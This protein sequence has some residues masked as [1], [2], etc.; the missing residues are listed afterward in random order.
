MAANA[1]LTLTCTQSSQDIANNKSTVSIK[2][3]CQLKNGVS[4]SNA[5]IKTNVSVTCDGQTKTFAAPTSYNVGA[6]GSLTL[7]SVSFTVSHAS[8]GK[9]SVSYSA[10]WTP[11]YLYGGG[12][13]TGSGSK[14]LT[15]IPR[16]S[17]F[18][19]PSTITLGTAYTFTITRQSSSF[20]HD[21]YYKLSGGSWVRLATGVATSYSWTPPLSLASSYPNQTS[22]AITVA[23]NTLSGSTVIYNDPGRSVTVNIP[24]SIAPSISGP[25]ISRVDNGVPASWG[26]Y[27]RYFS[28]ANVSISGAGSYGSAISAYSL[29]GGGY[30]SSGS[31]LATGTLNTA[32]TITFSGTVRDS[33]GRTKSASASITVYDYWWPTASIV[34]ERCNS[35]G[36]TN[37]DGVYVKVI[38]SY[39]I[40]SVNGK[41]GVASRKIEIIGTSYNNTSF[42][43]GTAVVLGGAVSV[44]KSYTVKVSV[45]DGLGQS[46][47]AQTTVSTGVVTIDYK[48]GGKGVAFGKVSE[49]DNLVDSAWPIKAKSLTLSGS[50]DIGPVY[51]PGSNHEWIGFYRDGTRLCWMGHNN[52][53]HFDLANHSS[54]RT[55]LLN[56]VGD[57]IEFG[58]PKSR[59]A[60]W[61]DGNTAWAGYFSPIGSSNI[62]LGT[63]ALR[64][65][66][67]Y[68]SVQPNVSS[69]IRLKQK[70]HEFDERYEKMYMDL[71][72]R[73]YELKEDPNVVHS[74]LIAQ[75]VKESMDKYGISVDEFAMYA[76]D[77]ETDTYGLAYGEM[78]S[79]NI[80]M[81]QKLFNENLNLKKE[82]Q[83]LT[84]RVQKLEELVSALIKK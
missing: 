49:T 35:N 84:D 69:D 19:F 53:N 54:G 43:S 1:S 10:S 23:V 16:K 13:A 59:I 39:A 72:P 21:V 65:H 71:K 38:A 31:T 29:S 24:S 46:A 62:L 37:P 83:D 5:G 28:K 82:I 30:S 80:Y 6:N 15:T 26:I 78:T 42:A 18:T 44:D 79:L 56:Y 48:A 7:G 3:V 50:A 55:R 41:N 61:Q 40:A 51:I 66:T 74:G 27:V 81:I 32:G 45:T 9:K 70:I 47:T 75:W 68:A 12:T 20:T 73:L 76:Y 36:T 25:S 58:I 22:F 33:R 67:L 14:T 57:G 4:F 77:K 11:P 34:A 8:D 60:F 63:S 17:T 52:S 64:W 2:V